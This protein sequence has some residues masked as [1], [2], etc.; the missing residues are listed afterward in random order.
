MTNTIEALKVRIKLAV[1]SV[2]RRDREAQRKL[3]QE[4]IRRAKERKAD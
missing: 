3:Y 2:E 4:I 1:A